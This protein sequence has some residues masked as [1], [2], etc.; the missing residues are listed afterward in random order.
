M[1]HIT[2]MKLSDEYLKHPVI[3]RSFLYVVERKWYVVRCVS[4]PRFTD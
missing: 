3:I 2:D 4:K 1:L